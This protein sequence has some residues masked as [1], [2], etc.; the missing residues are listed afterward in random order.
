MKSFPLLVLGS[1]FLLTSSNVYAWDAPNPGEVYFFDNAAYGGSGCPQG[2]V[3]QT[4]SEDRAVI[5][6]FFDAYSVQVGPRTPPN[7]T[8]NCNLSLPIH[9]PNGW[10]YTLVDVGYAGQLYLDPGVYAQLT[11]EYSFQGGRGPRAVSSW[12]GARNQ[13]YDINDRVAMTTMEWSP[14]GGGR[15]LNIKSYIQVNN[16]RN[17]SGYGQMQNDTTEAHIVQSYGVRWERCR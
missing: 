12:W 4:I 14:C 7:E 13:P 3:G 1:F 9:I 15:N 5:T 2:T 10:R 6:L 8:K 16:A 17:R 11:S